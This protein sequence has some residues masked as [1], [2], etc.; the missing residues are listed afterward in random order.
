MPP[1]RSKYKEGEAVLCFQGMLIYE[2]KVQVI[3]LR[4]CVN[5]M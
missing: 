5:I 2:A 4:N 1:F 3:F